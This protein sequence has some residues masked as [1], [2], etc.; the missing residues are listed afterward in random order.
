MTQPFIRLPDILISLRRTQRIMSRRSGTSQ[1]HDLR[2]ELLGSPRIFLDGQPVNLRRRGAAA[3]FYFL[4]VSG[5][6]QS[7]AYLTDLLTGDQSEAAV[8]KL[9]R[10]VLSD[11]RQAIGDILIADTQTIGLRDDTQI[12]VDVVT[13]RTLLAQARPSDNPILLAE[14]VESYRGEFLTGFSMPDAPLFEEWLLAE[15]EQLHQQYIQALELL[16]A[17]YASHTQYAEAMETTRRLLN[18]EPWREEAH[19]QLMLFL[20]RTGQ[21]SAALMQY[22]VCR[23]ILH[24]E[25]G[26]EP[27]PETTFLY[28]RLQAIDHAP[29]H[30]LPEPSSTLIGREQELVLI[31][32]ALS[33]PEC[34]LLTLLGL[35]GVGKTHLAMAAARQ[36]A[37]PGPHLIEQPFQDGV[38]FVNLVGVAATSIEHPAEIRETINRVAIAIGQ[39]IGITFTGQDEPPA[40]LYAALQ[41]QRMLLV[42][43][44]FEHLIDT[45]DLVLNL[46]QRAPQLKLLFTS[47]ERLQVAEAWNFD[48]SGLPVPDYP[49]EIEQIA[50]SQLFLQEARRVQITWSYTVADAWHI[51]RVCRLVEGLPLGLKLAGAA[52]RYTTCAALADDISRTLDSLQTSLRNVSERHRSMRAVLAYSWQMLVPSEQMSLQR[53]AIFHRSFDR[54]AVQAVAM[55]GPQQLHS[56]IDKSLVSTE[57]RGRYEIHEL[58]RQFAAEQLA[59]TSDELTQTGRRHT[60]YYANLVATNTAVL[61]DELD[62]IRA[63]WNWAVEHREAPPVVQMHSSLAEFYER[64]GLLQEGEAAFWRVAANLADY[65]DAALLAEIQITHARFVGLRG[66]YQLALEHLRQAAH[67]VDSVQDTRLAARS[68]EEYGWLLSN[69]GAYTEARTAIE[70]ALHFSQQTGNQLSIARCQFLLGNI[71]RRQG[72][73]QQ[74]ME[75]FA[76][77]HDLLAAENDTHTGR[78]RLLAEV[79]IELG[80]VHSR[81]GRPDAAR[82]AYLQALQNS[83]A[84]HDQLRAAMALNILGTLAQE[85]RD[86]LIARDYFE[87]ALTLRWQMGDRTGEATSRYNLAGVDYDLGN[88]SRARDGMLAALTIFEDIGDR[89]GA[90]NIW[91]ALGVLY[92]ELGEFAQAHDCLQRSLQICRAIHDDSGEAHALVNLGL[93]LSDQGQLTQAIDMLH[94]G[95]RLA[96]AQA[97][98]DLIATLHSCT[99]LVELERGELT[100]ARQHANQAASLHAQ[101]GQE[102]LQADDYATL[103]LIALVEDDHAEAQRFADTVIELLNQHGAD[104]AEFPQRDYFAC[105]QVYTAL[106]Q[107]S[108]ATPALSAAAQLVQQRAAR[109]D[110]PTLQQS[111]C[112]HVPINQRILLAARPLLD[113]HV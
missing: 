78:N 20:A 37:Q 7:R 47:R 5:A 58:V 17:A 3:V 23:Q 8:K 112:E 15:R 14:A 19:R 6:S 50:A 74:A 77:A 92:Q 55:I 51:V 113:R 21:R 72:D 104:S 75:H 101:L 44:N 106:G 16:A 39:A 2:L 109:I 40:Q 94:L 70:R 108:A 82:N 43:D 10:N 24:D 98:D 110:D 46:F 52:L 54:A 86:L 91:N 81:Q 67:H 9:V 27:V 90:G 71:A 100:V 12:V 11:L 65:L 93:V 84:H 64:T 48:I 60:Y 89:W 49:D 111:F 83:Q 13:F 4:A 18:A 45:T 88:Y 36:F 73:Y 85:Q 99:A 103:A 34:R 79:D 25:L 22:E 33:D 41:A 32:Q 1:P 42:L 105:F 102:P 107:T 31:Q 63:A 29:P 28:E 68:S 66:N 76:S 96:R 80:V 35:G 61:V 38:Y 97:D 62:N 95:L 59:L 69:T 30:N 53:I 87:Q 57:S 26:V 56:L